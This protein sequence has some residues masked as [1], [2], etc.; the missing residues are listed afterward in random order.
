M[1]IGSPPTKLRSVTVAL[2]LTLVLVMGPVIP[3]QSAPRTVLRLGPAAEEVQAGDSVTFALWV[4]GVLD[5]QTVELHLS[6]D[7]AGLEV[8]DMDP[9]AVGVQIEIGPAFGASCAAWNE[10]IDGQVHF[11]AQ[12]DPFA[13]PLSGGDILAYVTLRVLARG[14]A[15]FPVS[16]NQATT[17]LIDSAGQSIPV[18]FMDARLVLPSP[19]LA[20]TGFLTREGVESHERSL[21]SAVLYPAIGPGRPVSW[22]RA[23]TNVRGTFTLSTWTDSASDQ[24][25]V[26]PATESPG[27]TSCRSRLAFVR[28]G[29]AN[30]LS[31]CYWVCA[32]GAELDIGWHDLE[33]G[34]INGDGCIDVRDIVLIVG[35]FD[36]RAGTPCYVHYA[37]CPVDSPPSSVSLSSDING[38]CRV[39]IL[40]LTQSAGN[41]GLCSNCP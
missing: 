8:Q 25:M 21:V 11:V 13:G 33:G 16:F 27:L 28:L 30:Y 17:R 40:D 6:Y 22:G 37:G 39:D 29:F 38:D 32:D 10:V 15:I 19:S 9:G 35:D 4:E 20:L 23:C 14:P 3:A 1:T 41:F 31:E 36:D 26:L 5:L 34:D 18:E 7:A 12:R 24:P 2:C